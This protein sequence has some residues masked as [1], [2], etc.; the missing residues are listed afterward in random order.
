MASII[1][2]LQ[3]RVDLDQAALDKEIKSIIKELE[4]F[5]YKNTNLLFSRIIENKDAEPIQLLTDLEREFKRLGFQSQLGNIAQA[6]GSQLG[7]VQS[8]LKD[9]VN[10]SESEFLASIDMDTV[11]ALIRFRV[12]SFADKT[13]TTLSQMR[14]RVLESLIL[15][16]TPDMLKLSAEMSE[17]L[18]TYANTELNTALQSFSRTVTQVQAEKVGLTNFIY[19]GPYDGITRKFCQKVLTYK[20]PP[21]YTSEEIA[22]LKNDQIEPVAI[23]GGGYNCR[24]RWLA[25]SERKAAEYAVEWKTSNYVDKKAK[26]S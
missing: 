1:Q 10:L 11:E 16:N 22:D 19:V 20:S 13:Y 6:Y 2:Q 7:R 5:L 9:E 21:I 18:L 12:G 3:K 25:I 14:P 26:E 17:G 15:G 24:H 4:V 8:F 23:Y